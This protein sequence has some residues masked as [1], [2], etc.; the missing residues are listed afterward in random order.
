VIRAVLV[1]LALA[2]AGCTSRGVSYDKEVDDLGA[3]IVSDLKALPT[4]SEAAYRYD[5][6]VDLG[7]HLRV[8]AILRQESTTPANIQQAIDLAAKEFW[9]SPA[10]VGHLTVAVYS[11]ANPP[12]GDDDAKNKDRAIGFDN[13]EDSAAFD[14]PEMEKRYGPRPTR[15]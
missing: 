1:L 9:L 11:S 6:G 8:R 7:Q 13:I 5:H 3:H 12:V 2:L 10:N 4:V 14:R 15:R